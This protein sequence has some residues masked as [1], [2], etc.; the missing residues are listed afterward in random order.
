MISTVESG[1]IPFYEEAVHPAPQIAFA[2]LKHSIT[3]VERV[4]LGQFFPLF[5]SYSK[6]VVE[7][8]NYYK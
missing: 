6:I 7:S 2:P 8:A 3:A 5:I 1:H 4:E